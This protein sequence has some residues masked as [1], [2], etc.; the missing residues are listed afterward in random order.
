MDTP[1]SLK[2]MRAGSLS[3]GFY[4]EVSEFLG[5]V[6][7]EVAISGRTSLH[8][9]YRHLQDAKGEMRDKRGV[10]KA[11]RMIRALCAA[12]GARELAAKRAARR[13]P[14]KK[15]IGKKAEPEAAIRP[16]TTAEMFGDLGI[17]DERAMKR[18]LGILGEAEFANRYNV[19]VMALPRDAY[20]ALFSKIPD[21]LLSPKLEEALEII[22]QKAEV[23]DMFSGGRR[24]A[25]ELDY[26]ANPEALLYP[27]EKI[28]SIMRIIDRV[29]EGALKRLRQPESL[30]GFFR[31]LGFRVEERKEGSFLC[32]RGINKVVV[33]P[34]EYSLGT[35]SWMLQRAGV[36]GA[37][38]RKAGVVE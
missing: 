20:R 5:S 10:K 34:G 11:E 3:P 32:M 12:V 35:L 19:V 21:L 22:A 7:P 26:R 16:K 1:A 37:E 38:M 24:V 4:S 13:A 2:K 36:S 23:M 17:R 8:T 18:I 29:D 28:N 14:E 25:G 6:K 27:W 15:K 33:G 9:I 30:A 31:E